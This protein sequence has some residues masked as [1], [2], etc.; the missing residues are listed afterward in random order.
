[1]LPFIFLQSSEFRI[2]EKLLLLHI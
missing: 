1:V 2:K